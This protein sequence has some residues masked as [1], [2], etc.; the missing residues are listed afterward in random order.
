MKHLK[1]ISEYLLVFCLLIGAVVILNGNLRVSAAAVTG[2]YTLSYLSAGKWTEFDA[3]AECE[4]ITGIRI[5]S[6]SGKGY[7]LEYATQNSG[8]SGFY[9]SVKSTDTGT[10][11]YAGSSNSSKTVQRVKI[12]VLDSSGNSLDSKII[13]MYRAKTAADGWLAWV[14]NATAAEMQSVQTKYSLDGKLDTKSGDAGISGKNI[15]ALEIRIFEE[16]TASSVTPTLGSCETS[17]SLYYSKD[18]LTKISFTKSAEGQMDCLWIETDPAKTYYLEYR[19][20]ASGGWYSYVSSLDTSDYAGVGGNRI[21][22][23]NIRAKT[24]DGSSLTEG[25]VVMYRA[26]VNGSWLP[27]VSNAEPEWMAATQIKYN[28]TGILDYDSGYAGL[29]SGAVIEGVEIRVFEENNLNPE[30]TPTGKSKIISTPH[31]YQTDNYPTGCESVSAVMALNYFDADISVDTFIDSYLEKGDRVSFDPN[32]CFGGDPRSTS[33]M[34]CYAPVIERAISAAIKGK[35]LEVSAVY[36]KTVEELCELYIDNDIPVIFWATMNMEKPY[37]GREISYNG[38]IIPWI[39]PEHCLLLVGYDDYNYIFRDPLKTETVTYYSKQSVN[40]AYLGM[41][42]QAAVIDVINPQKGDV[43]FDGY[44]DILDLVRLK[45]RAAEL[46]ELK[47]VY[48]ADMNS[49]G[50]IN[51]LDLSELRKALLK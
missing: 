31:I 24:N 47:S 2:E 25:V 49:D 3:V 11:D 14:S 5:Q 20:A 36:G 42:A 12:R 21:T 1:K 19:V 8:N 37:T 13:V 27:W 43:N 29:S 6:P 7:Y 32:L 10:A 16:D 44:V 18:D 51:S 4:T 22:K 30:I 39:A 28:L 48:N 50:E 45:K 26:K 34:G 23:L 15:T 33:G 35:S 41:G 17:P 9:S 38:K 40:T 46:T